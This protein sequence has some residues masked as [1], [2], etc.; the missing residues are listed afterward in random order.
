ML[1][2]DNWKMSFIINTNKTRVTHELSIQFISYLFYYDAY[3][4]IMIE[5][6]TKERAYEILGVSESATF[7]EVSLAFRELRER[8]HP[9][10]SP[11][12]REEYAKAL[13][14]FELLQREF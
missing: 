4:S 3:M 6:M 12:F 10:E 5:P 2:L 1:R 13:A 9:D 7:R 8:Y 11:F 14:A